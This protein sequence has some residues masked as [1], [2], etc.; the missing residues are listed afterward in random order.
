MHRKIYI[1][2]S[3][4]EYFSPHDGIY[5]TKTF[6]DVHNPVLIPYKEFG[7]KNKASGSLS[8]WVNIKGFYRKNMFIYFTD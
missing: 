7:A 2:F 8:C 6:L 5:P 3:L 4:R 1:I